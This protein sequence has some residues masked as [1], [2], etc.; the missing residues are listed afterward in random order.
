MRRIVTCA[1]VASVLLT[2]GCGGCGGL[3]QEEMKRRAIRRTTVDDDAPSANKAA[4]ANS[5]ATANNAAANAQNS[6]TPPRPGSQS[7]DTASNPRGGAAS[8]TH[9]APAIAGLSPLPERPQPESNADRRQWT[10]ENLTHLGKGMDLY[11][12]TNNLFPTAAVYDPSGAPLLSWRVALLPYL[13]YGEL[14]SRF[15]LNERWDSQHNIALLK[16][17]PPVYQSPERFDERTNYVVPVGS[18]S[19]FFGT[20]GSWLRRIRDGAA[21]TLLVLEV[22]DSAAVPWTSPADYSYAPTNPMWNLGNL[23][24]D[25][26]FVVWG[27]GNIGRIETSIRPAH[28]AKLY[29]VDDGDG[30]TQGAFSRAALP[31]PAAADGAATPTDLADSSTGGGRDTTAGGA[32]GTPNANQAGPATRPGGVGEVLPSR[33]RDRDAENSPPVRPGGA[34][35]PGGSVASGPRGAD[36]VI[37]P[38]PDEAEQKKARALLREVY[39]DDYD[40]PKGKRDPWRKFASK[41]L[42]QEQRTREDPA[43]RYVLLIEAAGIAADE[44]D[45]RTAMRAVDL[46]ERSYQVDALTL[47]V[48]FI[49]RANSAG[50]LTMSDNNAIVDTAE[51][52]I[53]EAMSQDNYAAAEALYDAAIAAARR[54]REKAKLVQVTAHRDDL[55][56]AKAAFHE[57]HGAIET[58]R[59]DPDDPDANLDVGKYLCF[60]KQ[61]WDRGLP[62]LARGSDVELRGLANLELRPNHTPEQMIEIAD[63]WWKLGEKTPKLHRKWLWLRAAYWYQEAM[64]LLPASLL[65]LHA[66]TQLKRAEE[67]YGKDEVAQRPVS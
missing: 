23:R 61:R 47:R 1:L 12:Q 66:E 37:H 8:A 55:D 32:R 3:S 50:A 11:V 43:G 39:K 57:V 64:P 34:T 22:D 13:G 5:G 15:H 20:R 21:N 33:P 36:G 18:S 54:T 2:T 7:T 58:L 30:M 28:L 35:L 48:D 41:L 26:F 44:A 59:T 9:A 19:I 14:Y 16:E 25:G 27:D 24:E 45:V 62:H 31:D 46:L 65:K 56:E 53:K 67:E 49:N 29:T 17:I 60:V 40:T 4:N 6:A 52:L 42:A 10:I 51:G 63:L 38:V